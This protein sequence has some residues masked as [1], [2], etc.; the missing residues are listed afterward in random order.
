MVPPPSNLP[1]GKSQPSYFLLPLPIFH[2][3]YFDFLQ[4]RP[5]L[6]I[7]IGM[8]FFVIFRCMSKLL[9]RSNNFFSLFFFLEIDKSR[10][11]LPAVP[12]NFISNMIKSKPTWAYEHSIYH[13]GTCLIE[14]PVD[15]K[16]LNECAQKGSEPMERHKLKTEEK[17]H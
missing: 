12:I 16:T 6:L 5:S 17:R 7:Y 1:R 2:N 11:Y 9:E 10:R 13:L 3:F 15:G 14:V 4:Y 8:P